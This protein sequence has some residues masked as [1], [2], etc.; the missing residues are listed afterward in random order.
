MKEKFL[1]RFAASAFLWLLCMVPA[2]SADGVIIKGVVKDKSSKAP[3]TGAAV[4]VLGTQV[5]AVTDVNGNFELGKGLSAGTYDIVVKYIGYKEISQKVIAGDTNPVIL[6]IEL[7]RGAQKLSKVV[8]AAKKNRENENILL[9]EQKKSVLAVQSVGVKELSRKGVSDAEGAVTK[10]SGVSK[11]DGVKNVFVRGLGD[12]YNVTTFNGFALPS[13]DPEYKN[14]SLDFFGTDIIKYIGVNKAFSANGSSD[15]GGAAID[16]VSK[17][18]VNDKELNVGLSGGLNTQTVS[19]EFLKMDG[20]NFMGVANASEPANENS[21]GFKNK[22]NPSRQ[23]FQM[24]R[25]YNV[26]GGKRF[27]IGDNKTPLSFFL[28]AGHSSDYEYTNEAVRNTTTSGEIY[29]DMDGKKYTEVIN[30]LV[31]ANVNYGLQ[32]SHHAS[33]NFMMIHANTQSVGDYKGRNSIFN[34]DYENFG[35]TRRQQTN[36]NLLLVNQ[37]ITNWTLT[38]A[39]SFD[40]GASYNI[41]RGREPD[42]RINNLTKYDGGYTLLRGNSQQRYFS[43]LKEKDLNVKAGFVYRLKGK[44]DELSN[45]RVGYAGNFVNDN[46]NAKEYNLTAGKVSIVPSLDDFSLDD[47]YNQTNYSSGWFEIQKNLDEYTVKK[48]IHS[49][50]AEITY[51]FDSRWS[52]NAGAKYDNVNVNVDYNV[53]RGGSKGRNKIEKNKILPALNVRYNLNDKNTLRLSASKTYTLPQAKEISPYR[54][55]GVNFN[56]QGNPNL[57]PSDNYNIDLKWDFNLSAGELFSLTSFYKLIKNPISRIEVA[58]AGGYLSYENI[59]DKAT[60]AGLEVEIRKDL[61]VRSLGKE[62]D[63]ISKLSFGLNGSYIYTNAKI[64]MATVTTGSQLEG[65]APWLANLDISHQLKGSNKSL[66]NTLVLNYSSDK[67]YTI[68]TQGYQ[69]IMEEGFMTLDLISQA[70]LNKHLSMNLKLRNLLNPS[71]KLVRKAN[72]DGREIVLGDYKKGLDISLGISYA[73]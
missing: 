50:Y 9:L 3:L 47:Y 70:K 2:L 61:F 41:V 36:D 4:R 68:G 59:A 31:L 65:A 69:D 57:K 24:N 21:W 64:P 45:I 62:S 52:M 17:E 73:F 49:A 42:R 58:S 38:D 19:S 72:G 1:G 35:L 34:D 40:A 6:D 5:G 7:E 37:L 11:Q 18:L 15:V 29:K 56:S 33:Y 12:R 48:N 27:Y 39:A 51:E 16:I 46:F 54:Y 53:N 30:Q 8:V 67:V 43:D 10:V 26:T 23:H 55:V 13:E 14:I 63:M 60:V 28:T 22:L 66:T 25:S 20:V 71:Y 32:N 44:A